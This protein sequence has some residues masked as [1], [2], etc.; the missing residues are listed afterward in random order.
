MF[1]EIGRT[2]ERWYSNSRINPKYMVQYIECF[3]SKTLTLIWVNHVYA[4]MGPA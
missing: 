3:D 4:Q 1:A 2:S